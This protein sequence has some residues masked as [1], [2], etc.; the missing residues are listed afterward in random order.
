MTANVLSLFRDAGPPLANHLWQSTVFVAAIGL[1][2]LLLGRNRARVRYGVWFAASVKFLIP[3]SA[4]IALGSAIPLPNHSTP[5]LQPSLVSAVHAVD[6]PFSAWAVSKDLNTQSYLQRAEAWLPA[7]LV[8][9]WALGF[10]AVLLSWYARWRE[11]SKILRRSVPADERREVEILRRI[12]NNTKARTQIRFLVSCDL[13]EPGVFGILRPALLWPAQ[14]SDRLEDGH[15][16]AILAHEVAHV[17][18]HDNLAASIHMAVEAIFWFH[19]FV[20][21]IERKMV[22]ERERAC[23]EAVIQAGSRADIY[24]DSLLKVS[25]F[26]AELPLP[27]VS[28]IT[29]ADLSKRIRSIMLHRFTDLGTGKRLLLAVLALGVV[30]GPVAFGFMQQAPPTGQI[31]HATGHL[32]SFE[33]ASI[34]PNHSGSGFASIGVPGMAAPRDRFIAK[35]TSIKGLILWAWTPGTTRPLPEDQVVGGPSWINSDR[36]DIDAK[37][38]DSQ[39][40]ALEKLT[41][42]DRATQVKLMVQSL[43]ADRFKLLVN[44]GTTA[45]RP[46]Y[47]LV[48]AKGGPKLKGATTPQEAALCGTPPP[49]KFPMP[50]PP[51]PGTSPT[52]P[53]RPA[54]MSRASGM[55]MR[56]GEMTACATPMSDLA[57]QLQLELG[58][59]VLDQTGL[60]GNYNFELKWTPDTNSSGAMTEPSPGAEAP[61]PDA[62]GPSIFTA[63]QE[64][65]GLKLESTKASE[66]A[67]AI[68]H[69][70]KPSEN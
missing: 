55:F 37:L 47:A 44:D 50:P 65:L 39:I 10:A 27:C 31:L 60:D 46:V 18:R 29:G 49:G 70:E 53:Q 13:M 28:G 17:Q 4:L 62:S 38:E 30:A 33:V 64:Q 69:I 15:L 11:V 34:R 25:R 23:D 56:P 32:P 21:W 48:V 14:L 12:E 52:A 35:N 68:V 2:T 42:W 59:P 24:A 45:P 54:T 5:V 36:Y 40:A 22:E 1:L 67:I 19:P 51:P 9:I 61:P 26:C 3:F 57:R 41:P 20:W 6:Q 58:R 43:L 66:E 63:I 8:L 16:E 7:A